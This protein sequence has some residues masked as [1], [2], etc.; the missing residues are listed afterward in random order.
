ME[1]GRRKF[2]GH[3]LDRSEPGGSQLVVV[4]GTLY[5]FVNGDLQRLNKWVSRVQRLG[6]GSTNVL[7]NGCHSAG[8][9]VGWAE[10][11]DVIVL[12]MIVRLLFV[13]GLQ[14]SEVKE[15]SGS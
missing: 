2:S 3:A 13:D 14:V 1:W 7:I 9:F 4:E 6:D 10:V 12:A 15:C 5:A 11:S 8:I